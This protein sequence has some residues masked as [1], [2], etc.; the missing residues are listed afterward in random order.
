MVFTTKSLKTRNSI[1]DNVLYNSLKKKNNSPILGTP[2][3]IM[4]FITH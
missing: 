3:G 2:F 1:W 4:P